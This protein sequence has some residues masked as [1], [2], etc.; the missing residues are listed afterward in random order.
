[1]ITKIGNAVIW[2]DNAVP[3]HHNWILPQRKAIRSNKGTSNIKAY[4]MMKWM[5][6]TNHNELSQRIGWRQPKKQFARQVK[7]D[8]ELKR[9]NSSLVSTTVAV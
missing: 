2:G 5:Y 7:H 4:T 1:M 9:I 6:L 8:Y 3:V